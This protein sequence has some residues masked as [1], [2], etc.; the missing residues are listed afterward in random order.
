ME[1]NPITLNGKKCCYLVINDDTGNRGE[2]YDQE[3][4]ITG[5]QIPILKEYMSNDQSKDVENFIKSKLTEIDPGNE[6]V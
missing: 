3:S 5:K 2:V 4:N 1:S 6:S